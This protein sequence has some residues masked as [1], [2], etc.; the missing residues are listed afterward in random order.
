MLSG[1]SERENIILARDHGANE[2]LAKPISI[3]RI[4]E[5]LLS[6]VERPRPFVHTAGYFGPDR[7]RSN[8]PFD[9]DDRRIAKPTEAE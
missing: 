3:K 1:Y 7:R 6:V 4:L 8:I 2:F 5:R 9:H